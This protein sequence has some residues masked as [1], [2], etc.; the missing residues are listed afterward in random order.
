MYDR[1]SDWRQVQRGSMV[2]VQEHTRDFFS[3]WDLGDSFPNLKKK[4]PNLKKKKKNIFF[5]FF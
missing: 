3:Q 2:Q 1:S 4:F 5:F